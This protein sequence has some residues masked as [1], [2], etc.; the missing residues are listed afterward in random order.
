MSERD[1]PGLRPN[2]DTDSP[3]S[4][5]QVRSS[6]ARS[7]STESPV[8][9][10]PGCVGSSPPAWSRT[11]KKVTRRYDVQGRS[12]LPF[13]SVMASTPLNRYQRSSATVPFSGRQEA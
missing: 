1:A 9:F 10:S 11:P 2:Q 6:K 12:L 13:V 8:G 7:G 5:T 4:K 3:L